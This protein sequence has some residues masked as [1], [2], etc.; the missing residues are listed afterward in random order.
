MCFSP[1]AS[2]SASAALTATGVAAFAI[3][4]NRPQRILSG[5]P[6]LFAIQQLAE[7]MLWLSLTR[8]GWEGWEIVSMYSFLVFAQVIWPVYVP[9]CM[10]LFEGDAKRKK[11]LKMLLL[12][13][14]AF[15]VYAAFALW[16]YPVSASVAQHH[17]RYILGYE[18]ASKWYYGLLYFIPTILAPLASGS[19]R[20][21]W[22]GYLFFG[23]YLAAR[24]LFHFYVISVWCF[25]GAVISLLVLYLV[26][27]GTDKEEER[28][29]LENINS[30]NAGN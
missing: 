8:Q 26:R 4:A 24:L 10:L 7:G 12:S 17:I 25:F 2:F 23:S 18:L 6:I 20:L 16:Y 11:L 22:L 29:V 19:R 14:L 27:Y 15:S 3:S 30:K 28:L 5:I 13:G 9:L 1:L 21:H